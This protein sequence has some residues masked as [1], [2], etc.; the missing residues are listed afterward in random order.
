M[1]RK[2][3]NMGNAF[4]M[5]AAEVAAEEAAFIAN[6]ASQAA[7]LSSSKAVHWSQ[8][9]DRMSPAKGERGLKDHLSQDV[10]TSAAVDRGRKES[11]V[12]RA[13]R[14]TSVAMV[15][16]RNQLF[17]GITKK[18]QIGLLLRGRSVAPASEIKE[19]QQNAKVASRHN[20]NHGSAQYYKRRQLMNQANSRIL[21]APTRAKVEHANDDHVRKSLTPANVEH[22]NDGHVRKIIKEELANLHQET[23]S[24]LDTVENL[25]RQIVESSSRGQQNPSLELSTETQVWYVV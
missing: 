10:S 18:I 22:A 23:L 25:L 19:I 2:T 8:M 9:C 1:G 4:R 20:S 21:D 12:Q 24:R 13:T 17:R 5:K 7:M 16:K 6:Q 11:L 14:K 15:S 3:S